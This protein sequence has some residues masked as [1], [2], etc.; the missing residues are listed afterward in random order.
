M[1]SVWKPERIV[2]LQFCGFLAD[3][4]GQ[5]RGTGGL[6]RTTWKQE[7]KMNEVCERARRRHRSYCLRASALS[8]KAQRQT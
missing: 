8:H 5:R 7:T 4:P 1:A 2:R 6:T 3:G